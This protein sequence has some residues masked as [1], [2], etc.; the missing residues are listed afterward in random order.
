MKKIIK[1]INTYG[2]ISVLSILILAWILE[3]WK[4]DI[5]VPLSGQL[6]TIFN[7]MT[8][9]TIIDNGWY[10]HNDLIGSPFG[11][12]AHDLPT[13][14]G[15]TLILLKFLVLFL[16]SA[17]ALN[18]FFIITFPLTAI[19]SFFVFK[20]LKISTSISIVISLLYT[21]L[22]YHFLRG[23]DHVF[24]AAYYMVPL[25]TL[26][27]LSLWSNEPPFLAKIQ[28]YQGK[29]STYILNRK[30]I[31][32]IIICIVLGSTGVYYA[33]FSC[34]FIVIASIS[35]FLYKRDKRI[36]LSAIILIT[37]IASSLSVN[38]LP[39]IIYNSKYGVNEEI[40]HRL[41][42]ESEIFGLKII[43]LLLP[44][45]NHRFPVL[46]NLALKYVEPNPP[47]Q[48]EN[49][50][51]SL[52]IIAS[53][54]FFSLLFSSIFSRFKTETKNTS[55]SIYDQLAL[56]NISAVLFATIGGFSSIFA[57][58]VSPQIRG[59]N[60]ISIFIAF[61]S[62][63]AVALFVDSFY[64][65]YV[66]NKINK[67]I[68]N[69]LLTIVL[70]LGILD[71]TSPAF[72]PQYSEQQK[73][74]LNDKIFVQK[75]ERVLPAGSMVFQLPH[76]PFPEYGPINSMTDYD[77]FRGYLHSKNLKWSYGAMNGRNLNW[78]QVVSE[79]PLD[80]F[81]SKI[82]VTGFS[83]IY[84]DRNGYADLGKQ[85]ERKLENK[86]G[87]KPIISE[88]GRLLFFNMN[89]FNEELFKRYPIAE[90][91]AY[92]EFVLNPLKIEWEKGFSGL[93]KSQKEGTWRW[94]NKQGILSVKNPASKARKIKIRMSFA[95]S[96]PEYS[97]LRIESNLLPSEVVK[98]NNQPLA[99]EKTVLVPPGNH[100]IKFSSDA[101]IA[102]QTALRDVRE[103]VFR[104]LNF[105]VK[106]ELAEY[107]KLE[108]VYPT[109]V[110]WKDGFYKPDNILGDLW[111]WSDRQST[112]IISN[113]TGKTRETKFS[114]LLA[115]GGTEYSNLRIE[116][117]LFSQ[118]VKINNKPL[119][120]EKTILLPPGKHVI[121]FS[122]DAKQV[123]SPQDPRKLF[124]RINDLLF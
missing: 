39:S 68:F 103:I 81:L 62:L 100:T 59:V 92:K 18:L 26:V 116:S 51:S 91:K 93:E 5:R 71:Q 35:A 24:L 82:S 20:C 89:L 34:V 112:V 74:Y 79:E 115:S 22:P 64:K 70:L 119:L 23:L 1:I 52:G 53:L 50:F 61:F 32:C 41:T 31:A 69:S 117:N 107:Y 63:L 86:L 10:L 17:T 111:R 123:K 7:L 46:K 73:T 76:M 110:Q 36:F 28:E 21:F 102:I 108:S 43:H 45:E 77:L 8:I 109:E 75:I 11:L 99:F 6:D 44:I 49:T 118:V 98:I 105:E 84:I 106:E 90:I 80:I 25:I 65:K 124:F 94:S 85:I 60:R 88:N 121:K 96:Y 113:P 101:K 40:A 12:D 42:S 47:L 3:L 15:L 58:L 19:T 13:T 30:S 2:V 14:D 95:T 37:L 54:G 16:D 9:K 55:P 66:N 56:L 87:T 78:H 57:L 104:I 122:S 33:F 27:I 114:L 67:I 48:N 4:A 38:L 72:I 97:N 29:I 120:F 83:G